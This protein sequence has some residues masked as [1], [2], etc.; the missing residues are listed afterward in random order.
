MQSTSVEGSSRSWENKEALF[1]PTVKRPLAFQ[2][3]I[4]S[5]L[6]M[7]SGA[8]LLEGKRKLGGKVS[9]K[10]GQVRITTEGTDTRFR[11]EVCRM[12]EF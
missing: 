6:L 8:W 3:M 7:E 9:K 1:L 12:T 10:L 5:L 2:L 4:L 11:A